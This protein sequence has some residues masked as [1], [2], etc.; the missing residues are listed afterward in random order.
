[1]CVLAT[2][3]SRVTV[4]TESRGLDDATSRKI[5][6]SSPQVRGRRV[7]RR[8]HD[9]AAAS[10]YEQRRWTRTPVDLVVF[11][12]SAK[13][14]S[15]KRK[16]I[17]II[18]ITIYRMTIVNNRTDFGR[19]VHRLGF[20]TALTFSDPCYDVV[21]PP[22]PAR[23]AP[24]TVFSTLRVLWLRDISA[25]RHKK[26]PSYSNLVD[27]LILLFSNVLHISPCENSHEF[28]AGER[29]SCIK[30]VSLCDFGKTS[31]TTMWTS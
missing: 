21:P 25:R 6:T 18:L 16:I 8:P 1:V 19:C 11:V 29:S 28:E 13:E 31:I 17:I 12:E 24:R 4:C 10:R 2:V 20:L 30:Y 5:F 14:P 22:L 23:T 26:Y 3:R 7:R 9:R 27:F 15:A